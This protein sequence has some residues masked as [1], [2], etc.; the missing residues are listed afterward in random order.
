MAQ[1]TILVVDDDPALRKMMANLLERIGYTPEAAADGKEALEKWQSINPD[2]IFLDVAMP[3][4][5][6]FDVAAEIRRHE[7]DQS[8]TPIIILTAYAQS[9]FVSQSFRKDIDD[10]LTKPV[11]PKQ[12][13]DKLAA[14]VPLENG[15]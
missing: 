12:I 3:G 10:Y 2:L 1:R 14:V 9:Y 13:M 5:N 11:V 15:V 7:A 6:G 8:H 4:M